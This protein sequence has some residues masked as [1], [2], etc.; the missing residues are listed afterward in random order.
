MGKREEK[1]SMSRRP[2]LSL[3]ISA[4]VLVAALLIVA[5]ALASGQASGHAANGEIAFAA[6]SHGNS[7][8]FTVNPNG[9]GLRQITH[10]STGQAGEYGLSWSPDGRGLLYTVT[11]PNGPDAIFKS[12]ADGS[13]ATL[14]SPPCT[15]TCLG[16]DS[17]V[18][19]PDGTKIAFERAWGPIVN[20]NASGGVAIFTMNADGSD[21]TQLTPKRTPTIAEY[22]QPQ[23]SPD[24]TKIALVA[25]RDPSGHASAIE[26][27]NADGSNARQLTPWRLNA[28]DPRWSPD[29]KRLLFSNYATPV[30][31]KSANLLTMRPDGT[32][33]VALT[34]YAGGTPQAFAD[35]WS[36][37]G[38]QVIYTLYAYSGTATKVGDVYIINIRTKHIR[39]LTHMRITSDALAAWG[40]K[41]G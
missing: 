35:A 40:R 41:P 37:Y 3:A 1:S 27:M 10:N 21:L 30:Q 39:R 36:P 7:Q 16:D 24:G 14:I 29:G 19:S 32:D 25:Y 34:H 13:E 2:N 6:S 11:Y 38:T 15:G 23:W 5:A 20:N 31:F 33:R 18:Y 8:V 28:T 12:L 26:V 17:P 9:T 4:G 22:H